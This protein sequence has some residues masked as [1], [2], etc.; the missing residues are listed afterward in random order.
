ARRVRPQAES[1]LHD[2]PIQKKAPFGAFFASA[3]PSPTFVLSRFNIAPIII[4]LFSARL[5][6]LARLLIYCELRG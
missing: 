2:P 3:A 5:Y 1:I 6:V 4:P